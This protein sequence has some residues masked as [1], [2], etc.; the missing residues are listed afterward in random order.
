MLDIFIG[1][2]ICMFAVIGLT[3]IW[4]GVGS[5]FLMFPQDRTTFIVSSRGHDEKIEYLIRSLAFRAKE[6]QLKFYSVILVVD[7]GMDT[8]TKEI[9]RILSSEL[10]CVEICGSE[11]LSALLCGDK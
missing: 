2:A 8:Q 4:H 3:E 7:D 5:F 10:E 6:M 1:M 11:E 9:C